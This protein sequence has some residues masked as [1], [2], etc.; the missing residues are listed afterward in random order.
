MYKPKE[1]IE[2]MAL[3]D[4]R[5]AQSLL[6]ILH[7]PQQGHVYDLDPGRFPGMPIWSGHP[8]FQ[9]TTYRTPRGFQVDGDQQWLARE[10]NKDNI[11][12]MSELAVS[13]Y[14]SG[15]HIDA[16]SH[17]TSGEDNHWYNNVTPDEALGDFGP[18]KYDAASIEPILTRGVLVDIAGYLKVDCL[19]KAYP[20]SLNE[21]EGALQQQSIEIR[22]GDVVL[23]RTGYLSL[24]PDKTKMENFVGSGVTL[25]IADKLADLHILALGADTEACEVVPS[26]LSD[27]PHPVHHRLLNKAGIHLM[28]LLYLEE[29]A[30]NHVKEFLFIALPLK[31]SGATASM[32]R[33]VA[34]V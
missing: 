6:D 28:E 33:P 17:I 5:N 22:R 13:G 10:T 20:I 34:I 3:F 32:I 11:G 25:P 7:L 8:P 30:Q 24:W 31:I 14:H 2:N 19:P 29:L 18:K 16:L 4:A 1:E 23:I 26:I 12:F 15:A 9:L 27:N 21:F